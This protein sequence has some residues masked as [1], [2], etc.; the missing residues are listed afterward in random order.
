M[1][2]FGEIAGFIILNYIYIQMQKWTLS[3]REIKAN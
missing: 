1:C 3:T 2:D